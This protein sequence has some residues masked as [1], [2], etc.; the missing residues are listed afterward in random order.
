MS[1]RTRNLVYAES[2]KFGHKTISILVVFF[3]KITRIA[4]L[5]GK[6]TYKRDARCIK[7]TWKND[8]DSEIIAAS[9]V[10]SGGLWSTK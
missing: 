5:S 2:E 7:D 3:R 9:A 8:K 6:S 1:D 4:V 10:V